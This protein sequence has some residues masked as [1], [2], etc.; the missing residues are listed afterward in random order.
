MK[1][2]CFVFLVLLMVF[3]LVVFSSCGKDKAVATDQAKQQAKTGEKDQK[4][5]L[6]EAINKTATSAEAQAKELGA[7]IVP[8]PE[9]TPEKHGGGIWQWIVGLV[10]F[11]GLAAALVA[12]VIR[13]PGPQ[14]PQGPQGLQGVQ[15]E[16]GPQGPQGDQGPQGIQGPQGELGPQ[17]QEGPQ[18][19]QGIR[20]E[21]GPQGPQGPQGEPGPSATAPQPQPEPELEPVP[22]PEEEE[23]KSETEP[24][25]APEPESKSEPEKQTKESGSIP[26]LLF[27][28]LVFGLFFVALLPL[29]AF[30]DRAE[31]VQGLQRSAAANAASVGKLTEKNAASEKALKNL[32]DKIEA[33][34]KANEARKVAPKASASRG[35]RG[36]VSSQRTANR[37]LGWAIRMSVVNKDGKYPDIED[38]EKMLSPIINRDMRPKTFEDALAVAIKQR[39]WTLIEKLVSTTPAQAIESKSIPS[40][41]VSGYLKIE[42]AKKLYVTKDEVAATGL[43]IKDK[44]GNWVPKQVVTQDDL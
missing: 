27:A 28:T 14:G 9:A 33:L 29:P 17:G 2:I 44:D 15:G 18:G 12:I 38:V 40:V 16:P 34:E 37:A 26:R 10:A 13:R 3:S 21:P 7:T 25:P 20:G 43:M 1:K 31:E 36:V 8:V 23:P 30:A 6:L 24:K 32:M 19:P 41:D 4:D 22:E 39:G 42:E 35:N 11:L 5:P